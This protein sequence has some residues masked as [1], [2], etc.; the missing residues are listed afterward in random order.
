MATFK[1]FFVRIQNSLTNFVQ[2]NK[3]SV[4][5]LNRRRWSFQQKDKI[6]FSDWHNCPK[7]IAVV[8]EAIKNVYSPGK[9]ST[10][11][12]PWGSSNVVK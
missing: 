8:V 4:W 10:I 7:I 9:T 11:L 2:D 6:L 12:V 1:L 3:L 5:V